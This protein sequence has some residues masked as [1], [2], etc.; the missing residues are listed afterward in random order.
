MIKK[1]VFILIF[2]FIF[3]TSAN[4]I[5]FNACNATV[6]SG[7]HTLSTDLNNIDGTC[8]TL[9]SN[10]LFDC[11][12]NTIDGDNDSNGNGFYALIKDNITI[13]NCNIKEFNIGIS[14]ADV[15]TNYLYN[16]SSYDNINYGIYSANANP[17]YWD[18][19][20]VY[21][22]NDG[23]FL[24][25]SEYHI[26]NNSLSHSNSR[27]GIYIEKRSANSI[28]NSIIYNNSA[29]NIF[30]NVEAD[31]SCN[32]V[33]NNTKDK[34]AKNHLFYNNSVNLDSISNI[35]SLFLC[36][37]D[38]SLVNNI[39][40]NG[41]NSRGANILIMRTDNSQISNLTSSNGSA[42][43]FHLTLNQNSNF[44]NLKAFS[45]GQSDSLS[46]DEGFFLNGGHS[47]SLFKDIVSKNNI[48]SGII[49]WGNGGNIENI[50]TISNGGEGGVILVGDNYYINK[51]NSRL[52]GGNGLRCA[53]CDNVNFTNVIL[54]SNTNYGYFSDAGTGNNRFINFSIINNINDGFSN[55]NPDNLFIENFYIYNSSGYGM[56]FR[57][58][59]G[60]KLNN[61]S[62]INNTNGIYIRGTLNDMI[63]NNS[64][65]TGNTNN[66]VYFSFTPKNITVTNSII[67]NNLVNDI[68]V[69]SGGNI[70]FYN[71]NLST[72]S[73]QLGNWGPNTVS[74][75]KTLPGIGNIGNLWSDFGVCTTNESRGIYTVCINP[76][77]YTVDLANTLYDF[78]PLASWTMG[79]E[80]GGSE[81]SNQ[82]SS[83]ISSLLPYQSQ[84]SQLL[85]IIIIFF[86]LIFFN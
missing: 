51:I 72:A 19:V 74:F 40:I 54:D 69:N 6:P 82:T 66:G 3:L 76:Q 12:G 37:A 43:G 33:I 58:S 73:D 63:I 42:Y 47:G 31:S 16:I 57:F 83:T 20:S 30:I 36:N 77:N 5:S 67:R 81:Q 38:N 48:G 85:T 39:S 56:Y 15:D 28:L 21:N 65:F 41:I 23:M 11:Q 52:N 7:S 68:F 27:Y 50:T 2:S 61:I 44:T 53:G 71:N 4:A 22:N 26:I 10:T 1:V 84:I 86:S 14:Y 34:Q 46:N 8:F 17:G 35:S 60:N 45:N 62:V 78:A 64:I 79:G 13:Q 55:S 49:K 32:N 70:T 24:T 18:N 29:Y 80:V 25:Y 9:T 75:N 59:D